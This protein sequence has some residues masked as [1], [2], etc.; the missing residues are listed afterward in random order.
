MKSLVLEEESNFV[1]QLAIHDDHG[2]E[3]MYPAHIISKLKK[4]EPELNETQSKNNDQKTFLPKQK[5]KLN[6]RALNNQKK[7]S[8]NILCTVYQK[9]CWFKTYEWG[10]NFLRK[11]KNGVFLKTGKLFCKVIDNFVVGGDACL[12]D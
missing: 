2:N 3:V 4:P 12:N 5:S 1:S 9:Y 6:P 8:K 7:T 10:L 11:N